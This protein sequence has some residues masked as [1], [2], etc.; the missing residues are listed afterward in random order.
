MNSR[1]AVIDIGSSAIKFGVYDFSG[2]KPQLITEGDPVATSLGKGL[3]QGGTLNPKARQASMDAL[4]RFAAEI[5]SLGADLTLVCATEAVRRAA[6]QQE[7]LAQVREILGSQPDIRCIQAET[8]VEWGLLSARS[9]LTLDESRTRLFIDPGGSSNDFALTGNFEDEWTSLP[10]GMNDLLAQV[11][12]SEEKSSLSPDDLA[13]LRAFLNQ[14]YDDL[15]DFLGTR[16]P[17]EIVG[18][19]GAALSLGAVKAKVARDSRVDRILGAH[20]ILVGLAEI[21]EMV[22]TM[23]PLNAKERRQAHACLS[24][25]RSLIFVHGCLIYEVLLARLGRDSFQINGLGMKL[26]GLIA[27]DS[28]RNAPD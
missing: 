12:V 13:K 23:A 24:P 3:Q 16:K 7:F 27:Q 6:D 11:P 22:S 20:G 14:R 2:D 17:D 1:R 19:S 9:S 21:K 25:T 26:G 10:F 18:T 5:E 28:P 15:L 8:E 4:R